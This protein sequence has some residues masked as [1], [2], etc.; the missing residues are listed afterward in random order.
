MLKKLG[1]IPTSLPSHDVVVRAFTGDPKARKKFAKAL[2]GMNMSACKHALRHIAPI[3]TLS[4]K[5][6]KD[7]QPIKASEIKNLPGY[8]RKWYKGKPLPTW[9]T[10]E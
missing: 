6:R 1:A 4:T 9:F 10:N 7:I 8:L 3:L 2:E 5:T